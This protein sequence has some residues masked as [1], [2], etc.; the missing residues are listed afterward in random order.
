MLKTGLLQPYSGG[1][2]LGYET[3]KFDVVVTKLETICNSLSLSF[4]L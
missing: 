2:F 4:Y 1:P 3:V